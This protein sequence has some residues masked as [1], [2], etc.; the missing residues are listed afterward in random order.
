M[1]PSEAINTYGVSQYVVQLSNLDL[2]L[3][4]VL[5]ITERERITTYTQLDQ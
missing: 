3:L 2:S 4:I 1:P 5:G